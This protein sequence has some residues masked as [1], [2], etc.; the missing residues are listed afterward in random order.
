MDIDQ[1]LDG[2]IAGGHGHEPFR[3][4]AQ[5]TFSIYKIIR[6]DNA[7]LDELQRPPDGARGVMKTRE[8]CEV[9]IMDQRRVQRDGRPRGTAAEKIHRAAFADQLHGRVPDLRLP[10]ALMTTLNFVS[11]VAQIFPTSRCRHRCP[12]RAPPPAFSPRPAA[13]HDGPPRSLHNRGFWQAQ[14]TSGQS[15]PRREDEGI[16]PGMEFQIIDTLHDA[17]SG[18]VNAA[19]MRRRTSPGCSADGAISWIRTSSFPWR[20]A[21][22]APPVYGREGRLA[23]KKF[24]P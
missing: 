10:T 20:T 14:R 9:G 16:L 12:Q 5:S 21:A 8:Q 4:L 7:R 3:Q 13:L 1:R 18:S 2:M 17:A 23:L 22:F 19:L 24:Q 15:V 11:M 6:A